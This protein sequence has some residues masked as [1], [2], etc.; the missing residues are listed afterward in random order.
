MIIGLDSIIFCDMK[1]EDMN[2]GRA[3]EG[4]HEQSYASLFHVL[5]DLESYPVSTYVNS[6]GNDD[7]ERY[8]K[9]TR[10]Y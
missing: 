1:H 7:R 8:L 3:H 5:D 9:C 10:D 4:K 6:P 2:R